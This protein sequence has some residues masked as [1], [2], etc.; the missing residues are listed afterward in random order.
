MTT[1]SPSAI[2]DGRT[3]PT[4][5]RVMGPFSEP[6]ANALPVSTRPDAP[7]SSILRAPALLTPPIPFPAKTCQSMTALAF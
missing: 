3:D 4:A 5:I 6:M 7:F 1:E 2:L